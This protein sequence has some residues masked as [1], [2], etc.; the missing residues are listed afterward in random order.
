MQEID[1]T[2]LSD[3]T[4]YRLYEIKKIENYFINMINERESYSKTLN[5]YVTIFDYIDIFN[6][7]KCNN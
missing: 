7:F 5:R 3:Q 1:K 2:K 6:H 4:K